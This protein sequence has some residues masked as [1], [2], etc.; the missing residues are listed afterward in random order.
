MYVWIFYDKQRNIY[1]IVDIIN[2]RILARIGGLKWSIVWKQ[3][4]DRHD[5]SRWQQLQISKIRPNRGQN[6]GTPRARVHV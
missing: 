1:E 5:S 2:V 4:V 6:L 3:K